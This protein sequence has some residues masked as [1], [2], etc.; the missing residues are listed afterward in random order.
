MGLN[1]VYQI[2][3]TLVEQYMSGRRFLGM[4]ESVQEMTHS[5]FQRGDVMQSQR[6]E[7]PLHNWDMTNVFDV[8]IIRKVR[9]DALGTVVR[10]GEKPKGVTKVQY[11]LSNRQ[12]KAPW[13]IH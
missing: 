12:K 4:E 10:G 3:D 7:H 9:S 5:F 2:Y 1:N 8:G 6:V 13:R 11:A